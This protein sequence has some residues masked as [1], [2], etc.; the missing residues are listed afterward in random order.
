MAYSVSWRI[1]GL[2]SLGRCEPHV[3]AS[4]N[5]IANTL[6]ALAGNP[7]PTSAAVVGFEEGDRLLRRRTAEL[8]GRRSG[9]RTTRIMVTLP[10]EA[11]ADAGLVHD[12]VHPFLTGG[13][14]GSTRAV[15]ESIG[16]PRP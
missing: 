3:Q 14:H 16:E 5:A 1:R 12:L 4:L 7:A 13:D 9:R 10:T 6:A 8:F 15:A 2:S 11:A